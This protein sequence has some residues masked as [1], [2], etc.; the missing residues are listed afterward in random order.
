[1]MRLKQMTMPSRALLVVLLVLLSLLL[2]LL[3]SVEVTHASGSGSGTRTTTGSMTVA[4]TGH[5]ATLLAN[6]QVLVAGGSFD[7]SAELYDPSSGIWTPTGSL[8]VARFA[9]T[10]TLLPNGQVLVAGGQGGGF[11]NPILA[12]AEL[13]SLAQAQISAL[14][15]TVNSFQLPKGLQTSLDAKLK[16]ALSAVNAG[17]T[18]TACS[19]L[20][21]FISE[22]HAQSGKKLTVAQANQLIAAA[23]LIQA[24][25]GC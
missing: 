15:N 12:S 24:V 20:T 16:D 4:R 3:R 2:G 11:E 6:G 19:D 13:Y 18:A 25:L 21:D 22:V 1:M 17:N 8:T 23:T 14:I 5:T 9:H 10:A 7:T